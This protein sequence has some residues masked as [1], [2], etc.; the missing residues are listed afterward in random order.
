MHLESAM[1]LFD[2]I[3]TWMTAYDLRVE[4][5]LKHSK[6][7]VRQDHL[8]AEDSWGEILRHPFS[9]TKTGVL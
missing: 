4:L 3:F 6:D 9:A 1:I 7:Y 5:P 2:L 8:P